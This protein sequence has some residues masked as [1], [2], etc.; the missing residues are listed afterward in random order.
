[1]IAQ[2]KILLLTL[3]ALA[4]RLW[5]LDSVPPGWRDD[6]LIESLVISQ[7]VLAGDWAVY[8]P[9]ASGHEALYHVLNA[10]MLAL[11]GPGVPGIRWLSVFLGTLAVPLT[12]TLGGRL[13]GRQVGLVAAA[14]LTFSFWS[15]VYS[16][17]GLRHVALP[18]FVLAT[19]SFFWRGIKQSPLTNCRLPLIHYLLS[20]LFLG[21]SFYT[22]FASR[23]VPLILLAFGGYLWLFYRP[24]LRQHWA[25]WLAMFGVA[26]LLALPLVITLRQQPE[27]EARVAELAAPVVEA[28]QGDFRRLADYTR[29]TL[30]MF[31]KD[32]DEEALY[33]I[34][35]RPVFGPIGATF[36]WVG[37]ATA[38]WYALSPLLRIACRVTQPAGLRAGKPPAC[39]TPATCH[40]PLASA[41]LL[42]WW[43]AGITPGFMAV[44][45]ASLG[46]TIVAQP[47]TYILAALPLFL[48]KRITAEAQRTLRES[49]QRLRAFGVAA[50]KK[51]FYLAAVLL[52]VSIGARD[53]ADYFNQ[54]PQVE[55]VRFLYRGAIHDL[56]G[57]LNERPELTDFAVSSLLAGPWDKV[58]FQ[59]D[60]AESRRSD[61]RPRWFNPQRVM[62][63]ELSGRPAVSFTGYPYIE[64]AYDDCH[65]AVPGASV[66][67]EYDLATI[68]ESSA[69]PVPP[70]TCHLPPATC[71]R[72]SE[73]VCFRNGL[74]LVAA[75]YDLA[76]GY[77][78]VT[79]RVERP[80]A[81]P[82]TPLISSPPPPGVYA[83]PRLHAFA[84]LL[85]AA[86]LFLVGDDGLWVDPAALY[87]GDVFSQRH[88]LAEP[89]A[90]RAA[91][92]GLGL[93]DPFTGERVP[94]EDGRD[95]LEIVIRD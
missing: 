69:C 94:T 16:R 66:P 12:Y 7:K 78:D 30:S 39:A 51:S 46:H 36:F 1:M 10:G 14:G 76:G 64:G 18:V 41:F 22:Y 28:S 75:V 4:V 88:Y 56:A 77:L 68:T 92:V 45:A 53:L 6:E 61:V 33:N 38:G 15:L 93:Y 27:S 83:G 65:A 91:I 42:I 8:Y 79:W 32:G 86:G 85:D 72:P 87:P 74:C 55:M 47:A 81:L 40:L 80:L 63:L 89:A 62:M 44:P 17:F 11:F 24:L 3:L 82:P 19:F 58:A 95:H 35:H 84:Q 90:G 13:F 49:R 71:Y 67:G 60:L 48:L 31:H 20:G 70:A 73:P 23:G 54:W 25:G 21:L 9:D 59:V 57:Y 52:V 34:P 29:R 43:L 5:R 37:V 26:A 2:S 50:A